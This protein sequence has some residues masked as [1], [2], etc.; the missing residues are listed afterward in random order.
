MKDK[1]NFN[2]T[3]AAATCAL[4]GSTIATPVAA[5]EEAS[6]WSFDSTLLYYGESD[7]RVSDVSAAVSAQRDFGDERKLSATLTADTLT[8]ASASGAI[9][10]DRPQTFTS[11]SGRAVYT[12]NAGDVPLDDTFHDTRFAL[13]AGWSQPLARLYSLSA[14][15]SF[16]TE[17]DY[18]HLGA[19]LSLARDFNKRNTTLS[20]GVAW[21]QDDVD[22]VGGRPV[23][24]AQMLDVGDNSNKRDGSE[25]KDVV[26]LL[27]GFTQ[28]LNR[29]TVLRVNYSYSD[30]NGYLNDPYKLLS[31]VDPLTGDTL[32]R[33]P[34]GQGP[35]GVY[36]FESRPDSR[37][38][39]SLYAEVKHS[40]G[41]PVMHFSYR[42]M[43]DDWGIDSHTGE[44]RLRWPM[45]QGYIEPQLRYYKQS[46]ADFYH[47]SL[48][49]GA[50]LPRYA[51]ADFRLGDFDATTVGVKY[52]HSTA[53]GNEWSIR[54]EY[55]QQTGSIPREQIIGNQANREQYPD[56]SAVI[57]QF[58]YRFGL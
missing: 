51:S 42:F 26:D 5:Q 2:A 19:N 9:A 22:P 57:V 3:L 36:L 29:T 24:L 1:D 33:V 8:G 48:V 50:A 38:K 34:T 56:L 10:L 44:V 11:P 7:G 45:G 32:S 25:S 18:T 4:L 39:Q 21:S 49:S 53:G 16:S 23:P 12:T 43:T 27:L 30:S 20:A 31:V 6:R 35:D 28:V 52:G 55:Y 58:G 14:G 47:A 13:N 17:Y 40:F 41:A 54:A 37:T 15:F 46:A